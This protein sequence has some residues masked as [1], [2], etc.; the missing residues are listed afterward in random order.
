MNIVLAWLRRL[1]WVLLAGTST[2]QAADLD[3]LYDVE[4]SV[5]DQSEAERLDALREGLETV[6]IRI[7]GL[8]ELPDSHVIDAAFND[9]D[10]YQMQFRYEQEP[11]SDDGDYRTRLIINYD[12]NA[13]QALI[14]DAG[15]PVWSAQRPHVL[16]LISIVDGGRRTVLNE[17]HESEVQ[18]V[19]RATA[20]RRGVDYSQPLMDFTDRTILREGAIAFGFVSSIAPLRHRVRADLVVVVRVDPLILK[21]HRVW[22]TIHDAT[23]QRIQVFDDGDLARTTAEVVHRTADYLARRYAVTGGEATA[24]HLAVTGISD[25][26]EYKAVL[27]YL[28]KWEFID[29]VLLSSVIRDRFEFELRT[30]STWNQLAIYFDEDG[31]LT[32]HSVVSESEGQI[33]EYEWHSPK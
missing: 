30:A 27:D 33:P 32:P 10:A 18:N 15:L 13:V 19:I 4:F 14:R 22:L 7:T 16:F 2:I 8:R 12:E 3:W 23:G 25:I 26:V 24:L 11:T 21:Q 6:L 17:I 5:A 28:S 20:S 31:V 9:L 1:A 29:R